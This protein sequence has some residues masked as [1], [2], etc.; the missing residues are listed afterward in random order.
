MRK[1]LKVALVHDFL[2]EY[3]GAERVVETLHELFP[4]APLY[5]SFVSPK[6][7]GIHWNRFKNWDIRTS[8]AQHIPG[9][10]YLYSPLRLLSSRFFES[11][12]LSAYDLVISSTN[13]YM[14]KAVRVASPA[15]HLCYCHTPPRSLY[16]YSTMTDWKRNPLIRVAGILT[17]H[18]LRM[19]D[20]HTAQRPT[21]LIANSKEVQQRI[22][23]FYRRESIVI[24]PPIRIPASLP[25]VK[26]QD[27]VLFVGRLAA[28]KHA[29]LVVKACTELGIQLKVVGGG[30][31]LNVLKQDAGPTV[32]FLGK[33][34]DETLSRLYAEAFVVAYPAEDEDFGMIPIEAMA[35]GTPVIVHHSG[36]FKET[37]VDGENGFF[38]HD[39]TVSSMKKALQKVAAKKW[40]RDALYKESKKYS[41]DRFKKE[42]AALVDSSFQQ[43]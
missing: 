15:V 41:A 8:W 14:A 7:L 17:N 9:M 26:K 20:F 4:G 5:T 2:T 21:V 35:H 12:D 23:K 28:S 30:K 10:R 42:I 32:E 40:N 39:F 27:F 43:N 6:D 38:V 16:G 13:M 25:E 34:T 19:I 36:G 11:F 31:M 37:V 33:V 18:F 3:G 1:D 29:D 24:Y 22:Q